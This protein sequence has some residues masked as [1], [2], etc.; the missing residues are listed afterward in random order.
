MSMSL[1]ELKERVH[2]IFPAMPTPLTEDERLDEVALARLVE[3]LLSGGVHGLWVLGSGGEAA[4]LSE[5][6]RRDTIAATVGLVDGRVPV[7]VGTGA[8]STRQTIA[9]TCL[10]DEL[11]ADGAAIMAPYYFVLSPDELQAHYEAILCET[12]VPIMIYHNPWNAKLPM[13]VELVE[14]LSAHERVIGIK[15]SAGDFAFTQALLHRFHDRSDFRVFQGIETNVAA[16][17]LLGGHGAVLGLANLA[18][19]L[20]VEL[21]QAANQ[22]NIERAFALQGR[23]SR[24]L[25]SLSNGP[26]ASDGLFVGGVKFGLSLLGICGPRATRPFRPLTASEK[27]RLREAM[28]SEGLV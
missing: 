16:T 28:E 18:P 21:Y 27:D 24:L 6:V 2:G 4:T 19:R 26:G 11:G 12:D 25:E 14:A 20:C 7:L 13:S 3:H 22:G 9:D 5:T 10:A 1:A 17:I 23:L 15:D 8:T